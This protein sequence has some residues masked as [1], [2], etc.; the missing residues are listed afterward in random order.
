MIG[1]AGIPSSRIS[2]SVNQAVQAQEWD[3]DTVGSHTSA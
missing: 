1:V 3:L 2:L